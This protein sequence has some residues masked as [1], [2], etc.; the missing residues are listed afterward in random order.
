MGADRAQ[1]GGLPTS[2]VRVRPHGWVLP[3]P[4][5]ERQQ[6]ATGEKVRDLTF[7]H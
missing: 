3:M 6:E 1:A 4:V 5:A 2:A 7:R